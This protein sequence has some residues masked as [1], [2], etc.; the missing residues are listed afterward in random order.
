MR[1]GARRAGRA[2]RGPE[3]A[4]GTDLVRRL[5]HA[6]SRRVD[7]LTRRLAAD[8]DG[9][10]EGP[11]ARELSDAVVD[12]S[13]LVTTAARLRKLDACLGA[14]AQSQAPGTAEAAQTA[15]RD[16]GW[17]VPGDE[18][19]LSE[20]EKGFIRL[21]DEGAAED[22]RARDRAAAEAQGDRG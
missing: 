6:L 16:P 13:R 8:R 20:M 5:G 22:E 12:V 4:G 3:R 2:R 17:Q 19:P 11:S 18:E 9:A 15:A 14:D 21:M 1:R 7:D 10:G